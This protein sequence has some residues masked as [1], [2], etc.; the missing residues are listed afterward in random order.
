[1]LDEYILTGYSENG[2]PQGYLALLIKL[3]RF[4]GLLFSKTYQYVPGGYGAIAYAVAE[5]VDGGY[6]IGGDLVNDIGKV[7]NHGPWLAKFDADGNLRW[8]LALPQEYNLF[9]PQAIEET[10]RGDLLVGGKD[11]TGAMAIAKLNAEAGLIWTFTLPAELPK[12]SVNDITLT[13]DGGCVAVGS[14]NGSGTIVFKIANVFTVE[15][16]AR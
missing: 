9:T 14:S 8:E 11:K 10:P 5:T 4:G 6:V 3:D 15:D 7:L 2:S 16:T 1:M 13:E 12:G